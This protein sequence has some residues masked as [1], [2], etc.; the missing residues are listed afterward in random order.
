M[1]RKEDV[2]IAIRREFIVVVFISAKMVPVESPTPHISSGKKRSVQMSLAGR[3]VNYLLDPLKRCSAVR[4]DVS[5]QSAE[6]WRCSLKGLSYSC[7]VSERNDT[8]AARHEARQCHPCVRCHNKYGDVSEI[9]E[10]VPTPVGAITMK[11][12][13]FIEKL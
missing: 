12:P 3:V 7:D 6:A 4:M 10:T 11:K 9:E 1:R 13:R 2:R 8:P 5:L